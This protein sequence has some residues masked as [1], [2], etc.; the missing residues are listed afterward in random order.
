MPKVGDE[1]YLVEVISTEAVEKMA[2][3]AGWDGRD[4]L[5]EF[6]EPEDAA[7]YTVHET[8]DL[9]TDAARKWLATGKSFYGSAMIDHQVFE[10]WHDDRGN[11]V[12]GADWERQKSYEVAA[13][14]DEILEIAA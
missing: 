2:R 5:R 9:A 10:Q 11:R 14:D 12:K 13:G 7:I 1:R 3:D 8:L 6:C 4:G